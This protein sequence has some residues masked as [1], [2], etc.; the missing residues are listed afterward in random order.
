VIHIARYGEGAVIYH[1]DSQELLRTSNLAADILERYVNRGVTPEA[2]ACEF[3]VGQSE[4]QIL[5]DQWNSH[6]K[7]TTESL[8]DRNEQPSIEIKLNVAHRCN[9]KCVYCYTGDGT[10]GDPGIMAPATAIKTVDRFDGQLRNTTIRIC[11]FGGEPFLNP[12]AIEAACAHTRRICTTNKFDFGVI[13]N[14]TVVNP[15]I[16]RL[17]KDFGVD[18][19]IS[20]DGP[21][22]V[23]DELRAYPDGRGSFRKIVT[24]V[25]KLRNAL[26]RPIYYE[27][28]YTSLHQTKG[29]TRESLRAW[30]QDEIGFSNGV[31]TDITIPRGGRLAHLIPS[32]DDAGRGIDEIVDSELPS[33]P[34]YWPLRYFIHKLFPRYFCGIGVSYFAVTPRGDVYPCQFLI[35]RKPFLLM[36]VQDGDGYRQEAKDLLDLLDKTKNPKCRGCWARYLCKGCPTSAYRVTG[37]WCI[38]EKHCVALRDSAEMMLARLAEIRSDP[39]RYA[40]LVTRLREQKGV[41]D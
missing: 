41:T 16:T 39:A 19:T 35:G 29:I 21:P 24:N 22:A 3:G 36:N 6:S 4:V 13:T 32:D 28:T 1:P 12:D 11:F 27:A 25:K 18:V 8:S 34:L 2:L 15:R 5:V 38:P 30:L 31:V 33:G 9:L 7:R 17:L 14:G 10:Y 26:D 23:H 37:E 40:S 20:I